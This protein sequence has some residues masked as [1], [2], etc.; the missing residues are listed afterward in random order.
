MARR[1]FQ[2]GSLFVENGQWKARYREDV[3]ID[4][5]TERV[6]RS[7][8]LGW[9]KDITEKQAK[10]LLADILRP[11]NAIDYRPL[12][13]VTFE[14]FAEKW[15]AQI[16]IHQ[17]PASQDGIR[18]KIKAHLSRTFGK[19]YLKDIDPESIQKFVNDSKLDPSSLKN[20]VGLMMRMWDTAMGW[21]YASH[22]PFP[23]GVTG[24][25]LLRMPKRRKKEAYRF[26]VEQ[27]HAILNRTPEVKWKLL[28]RSVAEFACRPGEIAGIRKCDLDGR[29]VTITQSVYRQKLQDPKSENAKRRFRISQSL[30]DDL[31]AFVAAT[32]DDPAAPDNPKG[33]IWTTRTGKPLSMS[34]LRR[35]LLNPI[36]EELG[37]REK[38][39][40]AGSEAG[41]YPL[42]HMSITEMRRRGVPLKTIQQRVGH[43]VGSSVTDD[44]YVHADE[45]DDP[46]DYLGALLTPK[47]NEEAIQ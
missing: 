15:K 30:A 1:R 11:I 19:T 21:G 17:K 10:R 7:R 3:V 40:E 34:N 46:S 6:N 35:D 9:K 42:R 44:H 45:A 22:N 43:A 2:T 41:W 12:A 5:K 4:G 13:N 25:L 26:T 31:R 23:R 47:R 37:I 32:E 18:S 14:D 8:T 36:L 24:K 28:I 38:L 16:L 33:L 20:V 27:Y 39:D 29:W